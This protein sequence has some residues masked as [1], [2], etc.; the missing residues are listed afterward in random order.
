MDE[1]FQTYL[2]DSVC[3]AGMSFLLQKY[4]TLAR[5]QKLAEPV[6]IRK[7]PAENRTAASS[8]ETA[9]FFTENVVP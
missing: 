3:F 5:R 2:R 7:K 1:E 4:R 6:Q 8:E 9:G